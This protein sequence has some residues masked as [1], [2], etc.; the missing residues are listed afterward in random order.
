MCSVAMKGK[1]V[2]GE[3]TEL[4]ASQKQ[5]PTP[6]DTSGCLLEALQ[7]PPPLRVG[8]VIFVFTSRVPL[9]SS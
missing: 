9:A 8:K 1:S 2:G 7:L 3:E 6:R 4:G 5:Y